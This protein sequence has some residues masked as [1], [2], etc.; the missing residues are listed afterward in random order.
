ML[1]IVIYGDNMGLFD[2][3]C[4]PCQGNVPPLDEEKINTYLPEI[5]EKWE[6]INLHHLRREFVFEDFQKALLFVNLAGEVCENSGHH[7]NFEFGWGFVN[8]LIWTHKI[9]GLAE[10]DFILASKID[11]LK[12]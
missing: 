10:S 4:I 7:A 6:V 1:T 8:V 11:Q 12:V 2:K 9:D 3:K 5:D